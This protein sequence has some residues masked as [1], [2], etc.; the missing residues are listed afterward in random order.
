MLISFACVLSTKVACLMFRM[1]TLYLWFD[2]GAVYRI[3]YNEIL[4]FGLISMWGFNEIIMIWS[5][6]HWGFFF[7][8]IINFMAVFFSFFSWKRIFQIRHACLRI[9]ITFNGLIFLFIVLFVKAIVHSESPNK[10]SLI[11][12]TFLSIEN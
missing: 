2:C 3:V 1:Q 11:K 7:V 6:Y 5:R 4:I 9:Q 12:K 8:I 10:W